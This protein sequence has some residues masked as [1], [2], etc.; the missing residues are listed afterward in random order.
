MALT[1]LRTESFFSDKNRAFWIL[2]GGGWGA[3]FV[4]RGLGGL[5]NKMGLTFILPTFVVTLTGFSLTLLMA[6]AFRR[7]I[8]MKP[9]WMWP[10]TILI[11]GTAALLFSVIE[12]RFHA[13]LYEPGWNPVGIEF[14]GAILLDLSVLGAWT[15]LY[16]GINYYLLLSAQSERMLKV[17][18]QANAAQLAMLRYQLNPHFLFNTLNSI[19]TLVLLKQ[20]E[21]ANAMLSR[22]SSFLRYS[23]VGDP[24]QMVSVAQE[25]E[26]LRQYLDI[27]RMRFEQRLRFSV[28]VDPRAAQGQV[29]SLLLQPLVENAIKYA[30]TPMEEGADIALDAR[31]V[32][33]RLV[34]TLTDTGPGLNDT[35]PKPNSSSGVGLANIRD[36]LAQAYGTDHRFELGQNQPNGL[37]VTIDIPYLP[38]IGAGAPLGDGRPAAS[39]AAQK[40]IAQ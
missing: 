28:T 15:A 34:I 3:Y 4:L 33:D 11:L 7:I 20:T 21:R 10:L 2:Q 27:E 23:L 37:I 24:T 6:A 1:G 39:A 8:R 17:A 40:E 14:F 5:A 35:A 29:P 30:V 36:R 13:W 18:A 25:V 38:G 31:V 32:S 22:L 12:V 16:Y 19:S 26:A 9:I